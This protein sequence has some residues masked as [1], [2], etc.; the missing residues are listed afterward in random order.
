MDRSNPIPVPDA[1]TTW[2]EV[3]LFA[4]T[5]NAYDRNGGFDGAADIGKKARGVWAQLGVLP[6]DLDTARAAL[7]FEQRRYHHFGSSPEGDDAQYVH[8]LL[9]HIAELGSGSVAGP[10]DPYP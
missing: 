5:Y 6:G 9:K 1:N 4:L 10:P 7:F 2:H 3:W 8:A